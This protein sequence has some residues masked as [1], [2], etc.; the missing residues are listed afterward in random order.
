MENRW[1]LQRT[2][3]RGAGGGGGG[4]KKAKE[5]K[6][7][8]LKTFAKKNNP[9]T[10]CLIISICLVRFCW[11][12]LVIVFHIISSWTEGRG[13][14]GQKGGA[15]SQLQGGVGGGNVVSFGCGAKDAPH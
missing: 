8:H 2:E 4:R 1:T 3:K 5:E 12:G 13:G 7:G 9:G 15:G 11:G 10:D 6:M 14:E